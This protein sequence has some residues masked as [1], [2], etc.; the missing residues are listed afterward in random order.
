MSGFMWAF[1]TVEHD[2]IYKKPHGEPHD[3]LRSLLE[4]YKGTA[5]VAEV[6]M[7]MLDNFQF[8][9]RQDNAGFMLR[10]EI[11][12]FTLKKQHLITERSQNLKRNEE[13]VSRYRKLMLKMIITSRGQRLDL[14]IKTRD[15]GFGPVMTNFL[16]PLTPL[17]FGL[18]AQVRKL[19][20]FI[21]VL[22]FETQ[23][24]TMRDVVGTGKSSLV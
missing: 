23:R 11:R 20:F 9:F 3:D 16:H 15:D 4:I 7:E 1:S 19:C 2:I 14:G 6:V 5:N 21:I 22:C 10:E 13:I 12:N 24:L 17:F 8:D 18:L